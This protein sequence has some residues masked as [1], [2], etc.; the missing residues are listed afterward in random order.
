VDVEGTTGDIEELP[1][2]ASSLGFGLL[3]EFEIDA[4]AGG[5]VLADNADIIVRSIIPP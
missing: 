4:L 2:G 5:G 1:Q 3:Q